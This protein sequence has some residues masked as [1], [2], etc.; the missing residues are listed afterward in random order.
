MA[1]R[2]D[3]HSRFGLFVLGFAGR[4][5][6]RILLLVGGSCRLE[7]VEGAEI[8]ERI[9]AEKR[10]LILSF[11]HNRIFLSAYFLYRRLHQAGLDLTLLASQSRDG[12]LVTQMVKS[13]GIT[14][15]RGSATRGGLQA[16]RAIHRAIS[17][18]GS[19]PI[20]IPD[21]PQGP[22]Y[23]F[24]VGVAV[25]AQT[26]AVPILPLGFAA[27][28]FW[29][30]KSW[31][32]LIIPFP[33]TRITITVGEPRRVPAELKGEEL[34]AARRSLEQELERLT[35]AAEAAATQ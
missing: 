22:L 5:I 6:R 12:E 20:M 2:I 28:S 30:L 29:T 10:P 8:L 15:V 1:L 14:T 21:G 26:S 11:W 19:S 35:A 32:R 33:A 17:R 3:Q 23:H 34:E 7:V 25:L 16:L 24:K 18:N 31:D 27:K 4:L 13:W 9:L